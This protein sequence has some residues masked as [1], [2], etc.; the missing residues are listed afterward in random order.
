[1]FRNIDNICSNVFTIYSGITCKIFDGIP[2]VYKNKTK[3]NLEMTYEYKI[4]YYSVLLSPYYYNK[5][6]VIWN[7][8]LNGKIE[9]KVYFHKMNVEK[10]FRVLK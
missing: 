6:V 7:F 8:R 1:M 3:D 4:L 9:N 10:R 2:Y 5:P